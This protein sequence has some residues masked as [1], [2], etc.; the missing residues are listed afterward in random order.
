VYAPPILPFETRTGR[1]NGFTCSFWLRPNGPYKNLFHYKKTNLPTSLVLTMWDLKIFTLFLS[2]SWNGV[3]FS[4]YPPC[5]SYSGNICTFAQV[6][7]LA[8]CGSL[9]DGT[10]VQCAQPEPGVYPRWIQ[11]SCGSRGG[12]CVP[13]QPNDYCAPGLPVPSV[14]VGY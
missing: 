12:W 4:Q 5:S 9:T 11:S 6:R 1:P 14:V 2:L 10:Y 13:S 8:C 7:W 3:V